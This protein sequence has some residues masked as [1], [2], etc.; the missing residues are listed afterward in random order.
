MET[1]GIN[2]YIVD[3]DKLMLNALGVYL[4]NR[5]GASLKISTFEDGES[6]L[7]K[8]NNETNIVILDYFLEG[9]NG[10]EIL[11]LIKEINPDTEVI[12]LSGNEDMGLAIETFRSGAT[13]Y[14]LK[15]PSSWNKLTKL[16]NKI[17]TEPIRLMVSEFGVPKFMAIFFATFIAMG[18]V[19]YCVLNITS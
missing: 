2:L 18:A 19:V 8:I 17:I 1:Q 11:K 12:M 14:V 16:V 7:E 10:L 9:K 5:F 13:D 4:S 15:G 3:D 6:C